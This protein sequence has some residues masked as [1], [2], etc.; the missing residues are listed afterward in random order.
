MGLRILTA[1]ALCL[2]LALS[3]RVGFLLVEQKNHDNQSATKTT[4][5][6]TSRRPLIET[7]DSSSIN[8]STVGT[9]N[10]EVE[11]SSSNNSTAA[12]LLDRFRPCHS[13]IMGSSFLHSTNNK[14]K[15]VR[16]RILLFEH[17]LHHVKF[18]K[19]PTWAIGDEIL[20]ICMDGFERSSHFD[21]VNATIVP[22]FT[23]PTSSGEPF[24]MQEDDDIVW[25]VDMRRT[26]MKGSY[27]IGKQ[28]VVAANATINYQLQRKAA[29]PSFTI[30]SLQI[31]LMDYRDKIAEQRLCTKG[32]QK[33]IALVGVGNVRSVVRQIVRGREFVLANAPAQNSS[34]SGNNKKTKKTGFV[35]PGHVWDSQDDNACF[36]FPTLHV[37]YTV[38]SDYVEAIQQEYPKYLLQKVVPPSPSPPSLSIINHTSNASVVETERP[39][40]VAHFWPVIQHENCAQLRNAVTETVL[41]LNGTTITTTTTTNKSGN[42]YYLIKTFGDFVSK[43]TWIGRTTVS[44]SYVQALL[45]TKIVVVAQRDEWEDHYRLVS[46]IKNLKL[47][48][49]VYLLQ[50]FSRLTVN[51]YYFPIFS[52]SPPPTV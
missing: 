46:S 37:P 35:N 52:P 10:K 18:R 14:T 36:G 32:A 3:F 23:L 50:E 11:S 1:I 31:V 2:Y 48:V 45:T 17:K 21:L 7:D 25:V 33:L 34:V 8:M 43:G 41:A 12:F 6:T 42:Q 44:S 51:F 20:N 39:M 24:V 4:T 38:R 29:D 16:I 15:P 26:V 40:D 5:T 13:P 9:R 47:L 22:D 49:S 30:P 19:G 27:T 28:L